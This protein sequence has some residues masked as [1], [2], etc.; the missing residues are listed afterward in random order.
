M[1]FNE[2]GVAAEE[3]LVVEAVQQDRGGEGGGGVVALG[4]GVA[5]R[6][7]DVGRVVRVGVIVGEQCGVISE[8]GTAR[9]SERTHGAV[10]GR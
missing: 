8:C 1:D 7:G 5:E 9:K 6:G 3:A 2:V 4:E 10:G